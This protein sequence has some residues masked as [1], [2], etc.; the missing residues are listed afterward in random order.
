MP[1]RDHVARLVLGMV[2]EKE[3]RRTMPTPE[4]CAH[5]VRR[6]MAVSAKANEATRRRLKPRPDG[7]RRLPSNA[8]AQR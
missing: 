3:D 7:A 8:L 1:R 5:P 2:E 6:V 4:R